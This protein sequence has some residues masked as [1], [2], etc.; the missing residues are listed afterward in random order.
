MDE[1]CTGSGANWLARV[2][3]ENP[4]RPVAVTVFAAAF[5]VPATADHML[6]PSVDRKS[7]R[8]D[9]GMPLSSLSSYENTSVAFKPVLVDGAISMYLRIPVL[10]PPVCAEWPRVMVVLP[11]FAEL[12]IVA[13]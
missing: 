8:S 1:S 9:S 7:C 6:P 5:T 10:L 4:S 2:H 12:V 13:P 3:R 11:R